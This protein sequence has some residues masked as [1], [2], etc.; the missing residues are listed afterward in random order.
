VPS[1]DLLA[2]VIDDALDAAGVAGVTAD[3]VLPDDIEAIRRGP[4]LFLLNHGQAVRHV[5]VSG[6]LRDLLTDADVDGQ[7]TLAP[8]AA[9]VLIERHAE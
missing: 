9:M 2:A 5:T 7:A 6:R 4:A 1:D 8:G 3:S